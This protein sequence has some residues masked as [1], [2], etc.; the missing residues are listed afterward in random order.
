[1]LT[2][3]VPKAVW[4]IIQND[5]EKYVE[6]S[7]EEAET[8]RKKILLKINSFIKICPESIDLLATKA[9]YLKNDK[10]RISCLKKA[11]SFAKNK[12][13][14]KNQTLIS[15]SLASL[16]IEELKLKT[17]GKIWLTHLESA[18]KNHFDK[19]E[20]EMLIILSEIYVTL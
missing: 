9:D 7:T 17:M 15:S 13:D 3:I 12:N 20:N 4:S 19:D 1:M 2:Q 16:Y 5:V 11:F 14:Y 6:C 18:L 10:Q 8:L